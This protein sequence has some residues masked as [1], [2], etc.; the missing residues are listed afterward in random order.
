MLREIGAWLAVNGEAIY[1]TR[2]F[3]VFGEGPTEVVEGPFGDTK[4]GAFTPG[5]IRFTTRDGALYAIVLAWPDDGR[6]TVRTLASDSPHFRGPV[7]S[8]ALVGSRKEIEWRRDDA[9]LHVEL[10]SEHPSE[11]ALVLR[12]LG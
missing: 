12:I 7:N 4:R 9:G 11:H 1:G 6:V 3:A 8:V 2:P 10:P 5:D